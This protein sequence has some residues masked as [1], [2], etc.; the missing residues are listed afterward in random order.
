MSRSQTK[1][2]VCVL[3]GTGFVGRS[4]CARLA[5]A[6]YAV[7]VPTR[8]RQAAKQLLVLPGLELRNGDIHDQAT[9][10]ELLRGCDAVINLVGIL[11]E[12]G[13]DGSGFIKAHVELAEKLL[14]ACHATGVRRI[15]QM[16][17]VKANADRGPSHYLRTKG[18]AERRIKA[19]AGNDIDVTIFRPSVIFGPEDSFINRFARI[20]RMAPVLPMPRLE[21][22]F[23]PVYVEDVAEAVVASLADSHCIGKTLE[24]CG[25]DV[26]TLRELLELIKRELGLRRKIIGLPLWLGKA[27]AWVAD[28]L[29]PG[30]PFSLDNLR[31]LSVASVC[32]S[33]GLAHFG[34]T[35]KRLATIAR[36]YLGA[37]RDPLA[38]I[39]ADS[40]T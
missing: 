12:R 2:L 25:P 27:Q 32:T 36:Q 35:P 26:Y 38:E 33:N 1:G 3:G 37:Q 14:T 23:A 21:A 6:G 7:R 16:S 9:L 24:L 10:S 8:R 19:L 30:K 39:R 11:N 4:V 34:I 13:H 20:L 40:H 29:I 28:Y 5:A 17:A 18:L 15:V 22:T 31:S